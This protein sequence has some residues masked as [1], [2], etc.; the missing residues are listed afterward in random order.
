MR[1]PRRRFLQ[2]AAAAVAAPLLPSAA[3]GETWPARPIHL[4]VAVA[5]GGGA[6]IVARLIGQWLSERLGQ[7]VI[8][9]NR[10]GAGNNVGTEYVV[11]AP[12][13][14]Y[15]LLSVAVA[16]AINATLFDNLSFNFLRDVAPV[17]GTLTVPN[18]VY[19]NPRVPA[20][21]LPEFIAFAKAR[22]GKINMASAGAGTSSHMAGELFK[23]MAG[24]D[25]VH[26]PY[27]GQGPAMTD[28]L[29]GHVEAMF[30]T[31]PG[32][33]GY[34]ATGALRALAVTTA[35]RAESLPDI[36]AIAEFLPGYEAS[37]WYGVG[38]PRGTPPEIL[39]RLNREIN[40]IITDP[41]NKAR[42]ADLGGAA[43][44]GSVADFGRLLAGETE[45]WA[46][47]VKFSGAK[48]D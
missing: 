46:K 29:G 15:T 31:T 38:A 42:L 22:P 17:A 4:V 33:T 1:P 25:L 30:A 16:A 2:T 44:T 20:R 41:K 11:R 34:I 43:L 32:T 18:V 47:V 13:D 8:V 35:T 5:P 3:R 37:Q 48:P 14:G 40:A 6:D 23:M 19:V 36:P 7:S 12:P 39:D 28:L 45:K 21:T 26:V 27:R 24:V 10:P 9:E